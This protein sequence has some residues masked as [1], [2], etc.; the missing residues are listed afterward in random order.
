MNTY[1]LAFVVS[2]GCMLLIG[3]AAA[4]AAVRVGLVDHPDAGRKRH[5]IPIPRIG[6][7]TLLV[8]MVAGLAAAALVPTDTA[9]TL[10]ADRQK[11]LTLLGLA[12]GAMTIGLLDDLLSLKPWQKLALQLVLAVA[13][14]IV[15]FRV[16]ER[17]GA[18]GEVIMLG[19]LSFPVTLL[20]IVGITNAFNLIDGADGLAAG[21]ALFATSAL[22]IASL[23]QQQPATTIVLAAL[24]GAT[25]GFLR[26]NFFPARA[27]LGDSGSLLLGFVLSLVA[28]DAAQ[29]SSTAFAVAVP[30]V[31]LGL[32]V[33]DTTMSILRRALAGVDIFRADRHHVHHMLID[34]GLS[35][36]EAVIVL[37]AVSGLFGL[38][39]LLFLH[40]SGKRAGLAL[41]VLGASVWFGIRQLRYPELAGFWEHL[42]MG[43]T[44][45]A[46][47]STVVARRLITDLAG[48]ATSGD[49]YRSLQRAVEALGVDGAHLYVAHGGM[50]HDLRA[51]A[52]QEPGLLE[53]G[54]VPTPPV[55]APT[56]DARVVISIPIGSAG[57]AQEGTLVLAYRSG[58]WV[59]LPPMN[60]D[61]GEALGHAFERIRGRAEERVAVRSG[62][63]AA[64]P[65]VAV[66]RAVDPA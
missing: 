33:V 37:Y 4:R 17:W 6:G 55:V 52:A 13:A 40:P 51:T 66:Q 45:R 62:G 12:A 57:S 64:L 28:I 22:L 38:F 24:A 25:L 11:L 8:A 39:S 63:L 14:W 15:G 21:A 43:G 27:F 54:L 41:A 32:P 50:R 18:G 23:V 46:L 36:R 65:V 44:R 20:W 10:V 34:R 29:K 2:L 35:T 16:L 59:G 7:P 9:V 61:V 31:A 26:F 30:V 48:A 58:R 60:P 56:T 1:L 53:I 3:R 47:T 5:E 19:A 49:I 42:T